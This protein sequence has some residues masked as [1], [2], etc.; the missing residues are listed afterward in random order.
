MCCH[1][2]RSPLPQEVKTLLTRAAPELADAC[3]PKNARK[4]SS[5]LLDYSL[6]S[7]SS[8]D[9][10][11]ESSFSDLSPD[12]SFFASSVFDLSVFDF[13]PSAGLSLVGC[14]GG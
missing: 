8:F 2:G 14:F 1:T 11:A 10:S 12:L 9:F 13:S 5:L 6:L 7:E 3:F 4:A